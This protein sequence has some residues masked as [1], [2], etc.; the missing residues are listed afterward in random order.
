MSRR[1]VITGLGI[2]AP[3][4]IGKREFW[5]NSIKG[6]SYIGKITRFDASKFQC[7]IAGEI[8]DFKAEDYFPI[9]LLRKIDK[10][11]QYALVATHLAIEDANLKLEK[12]DLTQVGIIIGNSL[13]G[14]EFSETEL[15]HLHASGIKEVSPY[16][17]TAWFPAAPQGQIS[18]FYGIKGYSK[19]VVAD[20]A[21]SNVAVGYGTR[22]I[23]SGDA[24]ILFVGG[25]E[26]LITPY[27]LLCCS[28][29]TLLSNRDGDESS[30]VYRPFDKERS[31]LII[32][33]G[34]GIIVLEE[35]EH[36]LKRKANIYA[37]VIGYGMTSDGYH[38]IRFSPNGKEF[39]RAIKLAL[40][41]GGIMPSEVDYISAD[42]V[43]TPEGDKIETAVI[44][45]VFG[46]HAYKLA[47]S[48]PRSMIGDLF[49]ASGAIDLIS[50]V[51]A[52]NKGVLLPTIN[53]ENPDPEC[54]LDYVPNKIRQA[55]IDIA[56][57]NLRG[58]GG[59]NS[60]LLIKKFNNSR[61]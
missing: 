43:A 25:S 56:L 55:N 36:A 57:L 48:T 14:Q 32:G 46:D 42:G 17:A 39:N 8:K 61:R 37:E 12:E 2:V 58:Q 26:A 21:G 29:C 60:S 7:K 16:L 27:G 15:R 33:E 59:V 51:L 38:P 6:E 9:R 53:Y 52:M 23:K 1:V 28:T 22:V 45:E 35:L 30:K 4:G 3:S 41:M 24:E 49:G 47:I 13:G 34:A 10:F 18:I 19:T 31:G 44:K 20:R 50:T 5:E 40:Q 54:D 11:S